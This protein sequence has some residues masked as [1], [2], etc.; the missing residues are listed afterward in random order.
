MATQFT[1]QAEAQLG[2]VYDQQ[3]Q[4]IQSQIPS[5]QNLYQTLTQG[6]QNTYQQN[7]ASG[8]Q[9]IVEDASARGVLRSTLPVDARQSL[10]GQLG[11]ALQQSLGELGAKQA[12]DIAGIN[13]Q[14]GNLGIQRAGAIADLS[15]SLESQ[16]LAR[17]QL[18]LERVK[19]ERDYQLQQQQLAIAR[20]QAAQ[21]S[22]GGGGSASTPQWQVKAQFAQALQQ[23]VINA[24]KS[25]NAKNKLYTERTVLP[26]LYQQYGSV[27][28]N[29]EINK[30]VYQYRKNALGY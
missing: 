12:G 7:L 6:L 29:D 3:A 9:G 23:D 16:D 24:F 14:L 2:G 26:A 25:S 5:I 18:E 28:G 17:Q 8:V 15:K 4:A 30:L 19:A 10:T 1:Q 20:Q 21:R 11:A 27:L 22:S 13:T